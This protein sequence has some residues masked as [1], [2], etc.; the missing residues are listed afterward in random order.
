MRVKRS[1]SPR[2][3][4]KWETSVAVSG[5]TLTE[6]MAQAAHD[7]ALRDAIARSR[8]AQVHEV[9][10][11]RLRSTTTSARRQALTAS[12]SRMSG[13]DLDSAWKLA[14]RGD[15]ERALDR[16]AASMPTRLDRARESGSPWRKTGWLSSGRSR[17]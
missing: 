7:E 16:M 11:S 3:E 8:R 17:S 6:I 4:T 9:N 15:V 2:I 14:L 12:A 10:V 1:R 5:R 13:D